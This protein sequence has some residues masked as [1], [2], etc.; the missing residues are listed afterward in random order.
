MASNCLSNP[1]TASI[2]LSHR[3]TC[4]N[5][6]WK[7]HP[8]QP[9]TSHIPPSAS[10]YFLHPSTTFQCLSHPPTTFLMKIRNREIESKVERTDSGLR[11]FR[12]ST[13]NWEAKDYTN[14]IDWDLANFCEPAVTRK[15]SDYD[16]MK[17]TLL[18]LIYPNIRTTA[19]VWRGQS[20][21]CLKLA[22]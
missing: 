14:I 12:V 9:N 22:I 2:W 7:I 10:H 20:S 5:C 8:R 15:V 3:P 18:L 1:L 16:L 13:L 21:W 11:M 6:P 19:S 4:S 17:L